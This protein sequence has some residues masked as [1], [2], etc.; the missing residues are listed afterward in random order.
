MLKNEMGYWSVVTEEPRTASGNVTLQ[1]VS[2][3]DFLVY[4]HN[5]VSRDASK[6]CQ[7]FNGGQL[8]RC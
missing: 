7:K 8:Q 3:Y 5:Y 6:S 1:D 2:T 4:I